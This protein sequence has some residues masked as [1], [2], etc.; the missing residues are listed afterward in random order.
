MK[1]QNYITR[2]SGKSLRSKGSETFQHASFFIP[3]STF[4]TPSCAKM[5]IK[6]LLSFS[7]DCRN[8]EHLRLYSLQ[9][10]KIQVFEQIWHTRIN[11]TKINPQWILREECKQFTALKI[12]VWN[13]LVY[14]FSKHWMQIFWCFYRWTNFQFWRLQLYYSNLL[15]QIYGWFG[16]QLKCKRA[17][18]R[19]TSISWSGTG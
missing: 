11:W 5:S 12:K 1:L 13:D 8:L 2:L 17:K 7:F 18:M 16:P 19:A 4:I 3:S 6:L 9:F 15:L 14:A 10:W